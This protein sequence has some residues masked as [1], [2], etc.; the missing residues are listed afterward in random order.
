MGKIN[1]LGSMVGMYLVSEEAVQ[2][3][4]QRR[5][6]ILHSLK[7]WATVVVALCPC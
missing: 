7:Q 5:F 1:L 3:A 6:S 4:F 2:T